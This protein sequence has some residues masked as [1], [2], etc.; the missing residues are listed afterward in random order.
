MN[1]LGRESEIQLLTD[2]WA[3]KKPKLVV[4]T[5][6]R[7]IGKSTLIEVFGKKNSLFI[8]IQGLAPDKNI[9]KAEQ[10]KNFADQLHQIFELPNLKLD[11]WTAAFEL[12]NSQIT[13]KKTV[14]LLDEISWMAKDSPEFPGKLKMTWDDHFKKHPNLILVLC[15]S[16][17]TWIEQNI[18]KKT[19]FVGRVSQHIHLEEL[20]LNQVSAFWKKTITSPIEKIRYLNLS[21][22]VPRYLEELNP[23]LP[24]TANIKKLAFQPGSFFSEEFEKIFNETFEKRALIYK[25]ILKLLIEKKLSFVELCSDLKVEKNGSISNY[26]DDLVLS[27]FL[28][29]DYKY[30]TKGVK[31]KLSVYRIKDNY[32]RFYLKFIEPRLDKISKNLMSEVSVESLPQ[33]NQLMGYQ[34]ETLVLN[35]L[36]LVLKELK[37]PQM[38]ITS[39][40]PHFQK[41]TEKTKGACQIDLLIT[42]RFGNIYVCEIKFKQKINIDIIDEVKKKIAVL[43]RPSSTSIRPVL[44][45]AGELDESVID[46]DYFSDI[47]NVQDWLK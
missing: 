28:S 31:S 4:V 44:I 24:T 20:P 25:N 9:G 43:K 38:E 22:G 36:S 10:L 40:S 11:N 33:W 18:L 8:K 12:L 5:G 15:G 29:R 6:R 19:D 34:F 27:G 21:G 3:T 14:L 2:L 13:N 1:L 16:V 23:H 26:L 47:V 37:I 32:V 7:R 17:T 46:A 41:K 35:N 45:Y 39:C 42:T 30:S